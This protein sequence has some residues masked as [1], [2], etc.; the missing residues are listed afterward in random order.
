MQITVTQVLEPYEQINVQ[1]FPAHYWSVPDFTGLSPTATITSTGDLHTQTV[2]MT[3]PAYDLAVRVW[4]DDDSGRE[5][6]AHFILNPP[7]ET[8]AGG[9]NNTGIGGP[10]NTGIGGPNNT[11][12]GGPNN[13]GIGGPNN[14]GIG[15]PNNTGIGGPNNTGIGGPNNTGIGGPNNTG[16]GGPNNTGIGGPNNTGIGGPNNTGI[17]G[18]NSFH[19]PI[20]SA[21]AQVVVYSKNGFFDDNGVDTLQIVPAVPQLDSQPWLV[22]VG[23]GYHVSL[24]PEVTEPRFIAFT[25]LQRDVPEGFEHTVNLYF[26][27]D[28]SNQWQ[29]LSSTLFVE[30]LVVADLQ[31]GDG[32]YVVMATLEMP[33]MQPGWNLFIYPLPGS[34]PVSETLSSIASVYS[35]VYQ[36]T[37][38]AGPP[39]DPVTTNVSEFEFARIYWIWIDGSEAVTPYLAPPQRSP[40]SLLQGTD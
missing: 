17:G 21:D 24:K 38:Q 4:V 36:G 15:G 34:R 18:T 35:V 3:L 9:P 29:R 2:T 19:A 25:Y 39:D 8:A 14:T 11:G 5:S 40:E 10:N 16:I 20:R 33:A 1:L 6:I 23:Q 12:I 26:L 31:A 28:D 32:T 13:T 22:P 7:W 37:A 30:N 27:P